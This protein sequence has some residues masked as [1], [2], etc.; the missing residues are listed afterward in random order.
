MLGKEAERE[1][2]REKKF[3]IHGEC[4]KKREETRDLNLI[5][6]ED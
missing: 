5:M 6:C 2:D 1:K 4:C 3:D